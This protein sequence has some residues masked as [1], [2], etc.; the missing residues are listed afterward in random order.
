ANIMT[1]KDLEIF[2]AEKINTQFKM[3]DV[4]IIKYNIKTKQTKRSYLLGSSDF[5]DIPLQLLAKRTIHTLI[6]HQNYLGLF[7]LKQSDIVH[8]LWIKKQSDYKTGF[9]ISDKSWLITFISYVRLT[10]ENIMMNEKYVEQIYEGKEQTSS[11]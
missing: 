8:Y 7:L 10:L 6:E 5:N 11:S 1:S 3:V 9:N 2:V 4:T